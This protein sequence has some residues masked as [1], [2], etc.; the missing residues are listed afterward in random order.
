MHD[1]PYVVPEGFEGQDELFKVAQAHKLV[2]VVYDKLRC[3]GVW[4]QIAVQSIMA[5]VQRTEG[6]LNIYEKMCEAGLRP[7]VVK[8]I[9][10]RNLYSKPDCRISADEDVLIRSEE[11]EKCDAILL[12][13]GYQ[14]SDVDVEN[15]PQEVG[16]RHPQK[17]VYIELHLALFAEES[18][19]YGHLNKEFD[20]VFENCI[21]EEIQGRKIW[22]LCPTEH[23]FYLICHSFKH[24]LHGGFGIRQVCDMIMMAEHYGKQIDWQK[25]QKDLKRLKME[26]YWNALV[27]IG[28]DY[29]GFSYEKAGYPESMREFE[30][31]C[32]PMLNDLLDSGIYGASTMDRK[33]SSNMTLSAAEHGKKN[34]AIS[35]G[36]AL[37][38]SMSYMKSSFAWLNKY[39]W[40]LPVAYGIRILRYLKRSKKE[41]VQIGVERVELLRQYHIID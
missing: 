4:K 23:L 37:F 40:L 27:Q 29:L 21:C 12:G 10:C 30:V 2:A 3:G 36:N 41:S 32:N 1:K 34:T 38:P 33:H 20:E 19:A 26:V 31:D 9:V 22:T 25:I 28:T 6:F 8:G 11:F 18:G 39:P 7:L 17:G 35:V 15:L 14:R 13:E 24:F 16:Y 5:Q